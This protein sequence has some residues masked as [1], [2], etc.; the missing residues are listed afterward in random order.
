MLALV[1]LVANTSTFT[2]YPGPNS[3]D[4]RVEAITQRGPIYELIVKCDEG[5]AI[6]SYS[7]AERLYCTPGHVCGPDRS[8]II[9]RSCAGG[10]S[11]YVK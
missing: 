9:A 11:L 4:D 6:L 3:P 5:S 10:R 8:A 2:I 1:A 7:P